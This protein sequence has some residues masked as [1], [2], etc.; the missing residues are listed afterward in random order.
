IV[1]PALRRENPRLEQALG[2]LADN[3]R[4]IDVA[5]EKA[6][7]TADK[8]DVAALRDLPA[9]VRARTLERAHHEALA[10]LLGS[11]RGTGEVS[12]P[13]NLVAR[14]RYDPLEIVPAATLVDGPGRYRF[15]AMEV[16]VALGEQP[17]SKLAFDA[18]KTP[19]PWLLRAPRPGD[20]LRV[21]GLG[22]TKKL[23]D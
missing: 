5:I 7:T 21:R 19:L 3:L 16:E 10:A 13:G 4:E 20:R 6:A 17:L 22:G 18:V 1:M 12:L 8:K 11:A 14:R 23:S 15:G 9:P 2:R